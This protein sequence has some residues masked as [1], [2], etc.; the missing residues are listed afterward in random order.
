MQTNDIQA[1]IDAALALETDD[2]NQ[3]VIEAFER[4]VV[5]YPDHPLV[6]FE[7]GGAYD[8]GG[9]EGEALTYYQKALALG[10]P[11]DRMPSLHVQMG[12]TQRNCGL[13]DA[14]VQTLRTGVAR[15]PEDRGLRAFLALALFSA[16][17]TG[18]ALAEMIEMTVDT[19]DFYPKYRRSLRAYAGDLR[20]KK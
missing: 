2:D 20:G 14:A 16:G 3:A 6:V 15:Y 7:M 4:L 5:Q 8:S 13:Y 17:Q 10:L 1:L 9:R 18:D 19:P 11:E 12:S